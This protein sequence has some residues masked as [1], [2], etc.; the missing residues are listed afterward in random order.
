MALYGE[1]H[2]RYPL[3]C[4]FPRRIVRQLCHRFAVRPLPGTAMA[5]GCGFSEL[6]KQLPA[7]S[8]GREVNPQ[9]LDYRPVKELQA[10]RYE[11]NE[12]PWHSNCWAGAQ[13]IVTSHVPDYLDQL[14]TRLSHMRRAGRPPGISRALL[15]RPADPDRAF[16]S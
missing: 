6:L 10:R 1:N 14:L 13:A 8:T 4:G 16:S 7:G 5:F 9:P 11:D 15:N 12:D 3:E 2:T